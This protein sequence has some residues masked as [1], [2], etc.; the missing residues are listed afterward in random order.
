MWEYKITVI[1]SVHTEMILT[2]FAYFFKNSIHFIYWE[3]E[4]RKDLVSGN[5]EALF[6]GGTESPL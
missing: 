5:M 1:T 4:Q 3:N 2:L 6:H